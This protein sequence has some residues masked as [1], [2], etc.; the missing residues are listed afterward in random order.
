M[1]GAE[2]VGR[3]FGDNA[4]EVW[5]EH[6]AGF[7][8][9]EIKR[10]LREVASRRFP[11]TLGEFAVW[12]RPCLE[13]EAAWVEAEHCMKQ[14]DRGEVGDWTHPAVW[15][16]SQEMGYELRSGDFKRYRVSWAACMKRELAKGWGAMPPAPDKRLAHAPMEPKPAPASARALAQRL[17]KEEAQKAARK[18]AERVAR[19]A[20]ASP[21]MSPETPA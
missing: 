6:L 4:N 21:P 5:A 7:M 15:R 1:L 11:P 17:L 13:P 9:G 8:T 19:Q 10:G 14:R 20:E 2:R 3:N 16:A 12:C 18:A